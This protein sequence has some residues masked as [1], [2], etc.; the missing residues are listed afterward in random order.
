MV[1]L[2]LSNKIILQII[3]TDIEISELDIDFEI[4]LT[5]EAD[6]NSAQVTI[7]NLSEST[8]SEII[9]N[10][11][12]VRILYEDFYTEGLINVYT[13]FKRSKVEQKSSK[14]GSSKT[15]R[16]VGLENVGSDV[17]TVLYLAENLNNFSNS[18]FSKSYTTEVSSKTIISDVAKTMQAGTF[19][20]APV[21]H[22]VYKNG[23]SFHENSRT[24]LSRVCKTID[25]N[26]SLTQSAVNISPIKT[27]IQQSTFLFDGDTIDSPKPLDNDEF[28]FE[29]RFVPQL[30]PDM[31]VRVET[32]DYNG[33]YK[34]TKI[35]H[36]ASN[37]GDKCVSEITLK[38]N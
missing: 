30:K 5:N 27:K 14:G 37:H 8:R 25:C 38:E 16:Q 29:T 11:T 17:G 10:F 36:S 9:Q 34:I 18:F 15:K 23:I 3:G 32:R 1:Q 12:A 22:I 26:W 35:K 33:T 2:D 7:W 31:W 24:A 28:S 20:Q 19:Y 21:N 4:E 13:G 6:P